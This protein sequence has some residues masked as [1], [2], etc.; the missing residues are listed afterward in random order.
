MRCVSFF[1][2]RRHTTASRLLLSRHRRGSW[3]LGIRCGK[4]PCKICIFRCP[5]LRA[6]APRRARARRDSPA[7]TATAICLGR[8][9]YVSKRAGSLGGRESERRATNAGYGKK[10]SSQARR[11]FFFTRRRIVSL[12][13]GGFERVSRRAALPTAIQL[14][15]Q[16]LFNGYSTAIRRLFNGLPPARAL[17][18]I[19]ARRPRRWAR[20][21]AEKKKRE[22]GERLVASRTFLTVL[23]GFARTR[24]VFK[25]TN[26]TREPLRLSGR[27]RAAARATCDAPTESMCLSFLMKYL[28]RLYGVQIGLVKS[29]QRT[30]AHVSRKAL[31]NTLRGPTVRRQSRPLSQTPNVAFSR[32]DTGTGTPRATSRARRASRPRPSPRLRRLRWKRK[33]GENGEA[34]ETREGKKK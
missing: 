22:K 15:F 13:R 12:S 19:G 23:R 10:G 24:G 29:V 25:R 2:H 30:L 11:A 3:S 32:K 6:R 16:L 7:R 18:A 14:L 21:S 26:N 4:G 20:A 33:T 1:L 34:K 27:G 31:Q 28:G 8:W 17:A 9:K 5:N